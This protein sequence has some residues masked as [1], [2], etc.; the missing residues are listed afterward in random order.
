[1]SIGVFLVDDHDLVRMSMKHI[2]SAI[3]GIEVVGEASSGEE[4]LER[5]PTAKPN[6]VLMD[7]KLPAKNGLETSR[8]LL[9]QDPNLQ[10]I[11]VSALGIDQFL[12][13]KLFHDGVKGFLSKNSN[14]EEMEKAIRAVQSG[15]RYVNPT[16]TRELGI[17][18]AEET[19]IFPFDNLSER[20]LQ[21]AILILQG[22]TIPEIIKKLDIT[23]KTIYSYQVRIFEKLRVTNKIQL[24]LLAERHGFTRYL[25]RGEDA[26]N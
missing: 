25:W 8:E 16:V 11:M 17:K 6:V 4:A 18:T 2:L 20:E 12:L 24:T 10:I 3:S 1:M 5:I 13:S 7:Y 21:V 23:R 19:Y 14:S 15:R 9:A 22:L 26:T